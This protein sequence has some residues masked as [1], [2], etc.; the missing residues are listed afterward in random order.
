[1]KLSISTKKNQETIGSLKHSLKKRSL[2]LH[3]FSHSLQKRKQTLKVPQAVHLWEKLEKAVSK[4]SLN[5]RYNDWTFQFL[6]AVTKKMLETNSGSRPLSNLN[7]VKSLS[8]SS[9]NRQVG[10]F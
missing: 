9:K 6:A 8:S 7:F 2:K 1:L 3:S 10:Y 4:K 5:T